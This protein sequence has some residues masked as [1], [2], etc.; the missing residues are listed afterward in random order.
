LNDAVILRSGHGAG[1][2][3][4]PYANA[5]EVMIRRIQK[6]L[7]RDVTRSV[8]GTIILKVVSGFV[9]FAMFSLAARNMAPDQF[10]NL[11]MWLSVA[12]IGCVIGLFGQEMLVVR[13]LGEYSSANQP[14]SIKGILLFSNGLALIL[15]ILASLVVVGF[16][17]LVRH[18]S[19]MLLLAVASFMIVNAAIMLGSQ[20]ARSLVG[21]LMGEGNR[22]L[23]WRLLV[24]IALLAALGTHRGISP[25]E[26]LILSAAAMSL[27]LMV[28]AIGIWNALS[29]EIRRSQPA[30]DTRRWL[31]ASVRFWL[32]S[33]LEASSQY[34][35][36]VV[37]YWL[38]DPAAAGIYFAASRLANVFAMLLG[39][40]NSFATRRLPGLY[41]AKARVEIER[42]LMLMA[43]VSAICV[44]IG[45]MI[46]TFGAAA[47]LGLFGTAFAT[48]KWTLS[49]LAVGTAI[50]AAGGPAPAILQ[51]TGHEGIYVPVVGGNVALRL[52]GFLILIPLFGVLGAA[53]SCTVSLVITTIVLNT[54]CRH[55]TGLDPSI[56]FLLRRIAVG[57]HVAQ[58]VAV[59]PMQHR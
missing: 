51:L 42:S 41:F 45:L 11:A 28:Q 21:I 1:P 3:A 33:I 6:L 5:D 13:S 18:D 20:I 15:S 35:D 25:E 31:G 47:L 8:I 57:P 14:G 50:Q 30:F 22:D 24:V 32:S 9:A 34:F 12:Q 58:P 55:R 23:F 48:Y 7:T 27:G 4:L 17:W 56:F 19:P 52:F 59:A 43:E 46:F 37:I 39:A 40:L 36:V 2:R 54:L 16:A 53:I 44:A 26:F 38:L 29:G 10:G 49:V